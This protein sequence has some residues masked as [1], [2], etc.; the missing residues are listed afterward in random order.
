MLWLTP[1][2]VSP[3]NDNGYDVANYYEIDPIYGTLDDLKRLIKEAEK[4]EIGLML[5]MVFNHTSTHHEWFRKAMEGD[6]YYKD[7][8][9]FKKGRNHQPPTNWESKFGGNA[10]EY[11]EAFDEYYLHLYDVTQADLNWENPNVVKEMAK[12]V[13]Y[14]LDMGITGF[15]FDVINLISKES[16]EDDFEGVGKRFYT[17]CKK[18]NDY[19]RE[20]NERS[21]GR[22]EDTITVGEMSATTIEN[23]IRYSKPENHE[24]DMTFNFHHLKV[25][26]LNK[27]KWSLMPF[28]FMELKQLFNKWQTGM[29]DGGGWNTLFWCCHDQ[30]RIVSR[31]GSDQEYHRESAKMLA[32]AMH[33][34]RGT[35][36]I[37][38][39]E[40]LG[41]TNAYF[42]DLT[43]YRDIE[44]INHF[45]ILKNQGLKEEEI[46]AILQSKSRDNA[47]TPMQWDNTLNAGFSDQTPWI[48][49][50]PN[51]LYINAEAALQ[52]HDS[53]FYHYAQLIQL[54]K[55][56]PVIQ[57]GLYEPML[58]ESE[59]V[60]A[61]QRRL[62]TESMLVMN[63]FYAKEATI[64]LEDI[65]GYQLLLSNYPVQQLNKEFTLRPYESCVYYR[66]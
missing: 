57:D 6:P 13:N 22:C 14:W 39:G 31:F 48:Q 37:Y 58:E 16:F 36:Y 38:Q 63:N 35:P 59:Q 12:I 17:D 5:D 26:Y 60:F 62:G 24:L 3:Q 44:S 33:M 46:Y 42:T 43:Q 52:D 53:I 61:Y 50:N 21:F 32:T 8:Y 28:D 30:P 49:V 66:K 9:F 7:F 45:H 65:D 25:D 34:M 41:M 2:F 55:H 23:C 56:Y 4:R 64:H 11:V 40:E 51:Y 18:V 54:R 47:R 20:L 29:Q 15:R 27:E 19:L 1:F 10:W